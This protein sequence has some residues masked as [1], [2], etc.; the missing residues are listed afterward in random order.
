MKHLRAITMCGTFIP[1]C[2]YEYSNFKLIGD[3]YCP[4]AKCSGEICLQKDFS[5]SWQ[6]LLSM[7]TRRVCV[8]G[9]HYSFWRSNKFL[10]LD[11]WSRGVYISEESPKSIQIVIG[12][13][14]CPVKYCFNREECEC[15]DGY[16][17]TPRSIYDCAKCWAWLFVQ[18]V[19][20]TSQEHVKTI[21]AEKIRYFL[22]KKMNFLPNKQLFKKV[23]FQ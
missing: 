22:L 5:I 10:L 19:P 2:R 8:P 9:E 15:F 13:V 1:D 23:P 7:S 11:V 4:T 20:F 12:D 17:T 18:R 3:V 16:V 6:K 14:F 21:E